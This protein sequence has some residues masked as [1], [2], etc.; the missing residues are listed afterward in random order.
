MAQLTR[1]QLRRFGLTPDTN[2][3][4]H[5]LV[6]NNVLDVIERL[7]ELTPDDVCYE[8]GVGVGVLTDYLARRVR[9]VHGVEMDHRL[10]PA[11][12]A[13]SADL[14]NVT[15]HW[16]DATEL[17]PAT[18][19]PEP[20]KMVSN[21]PYHVAAP[22]VAEA[23][24]H[25]PGLRFYCVMVQREIGDRFFA[26]EGSKGY[27]ALSVL[28][29]TTCERTGMHKVSRSVFV[30]PPNVDSV[31]IAFRR[32]DRLLAPDRVPAFAAFTKTA[33]MHRRKTLANNLQTAG[34][35]L[36]EA[37]VAAL[38]EVDL[39]PAARPEQLSPER[40]VAVFDRLGGARIADRVVDA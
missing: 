24:Q 34:I 14:A 1:D 19:T 22:I 3:G 30:P 8:P 4:Q 38:A 16:S 23:L 25:A 39:P 9:H 5:F 13:M 29:R 7:A 11:I 31:L 10:E 2:L 17:D 21:L 32:T 6:D 33:F 12:D 37:T 28:L 15:I 35:A 40:F 27:N 18:L 36:R 26:D 20:T